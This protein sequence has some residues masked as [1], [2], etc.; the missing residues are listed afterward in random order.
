M[1]SIDSPGIIIGMLR[2]DGTFPGD[3]QCASIWSYQTV[4]GT[5]CFKLIYG[6]HPVQ[7]VNEFLLS[8][9]V[10]EP[11]MLWGKKEGLTP[12]AQALFEEYPT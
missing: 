11:R 7:M 6:P 8:P 2:N 10:L 1:S 5:R 3:P 4:F 9:Y 12:A